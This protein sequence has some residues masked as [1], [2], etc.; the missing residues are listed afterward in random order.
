MAGVLLGV[1]PT[2]A[3]WRAAA[4]VAESMSQHECHGCRGCD[5]FYEVLLM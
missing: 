1:D 3:S 2:F 5:S 4:M